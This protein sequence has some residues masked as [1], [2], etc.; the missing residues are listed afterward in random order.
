MIE[1][2]HVIVLFGWIAN[3]TKALQ[4]FPQVVQNYNNY[5]EC[6]DLLVSEESSELL[7]RMYYLQASGTNP[8]FLAINTVS[9]LCMIIYTGL[10]LL[11]GLHEF[12]P[13]FIGNIIVF[14][15]TLVVVFWRRRII[16]SVLR[17]YP[18]IEEEKRLN[19]LAHEGT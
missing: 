3:I 14:V 17:L 15:A 18:V 12:L 8:T 10:A 2:Q 19:Q 5:C 16:T 7:A 4:F 9:V 1:V 6:S 11:E 13:A